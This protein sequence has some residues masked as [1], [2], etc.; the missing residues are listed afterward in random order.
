MS[1]PTIT[2]IFDDFGIAVGPYSSGQISDDR[3]PTLSG[4]LTKKLKKGES[5]FIYSGNDFIGKAETKGKNFSLVSES[6]LKAN[7]T[8]SFKA[9]H[10]NKKGKEGKASKPYILTMTTN[11]LPSLSLMLMG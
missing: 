5:I 11:P 10:V 3:T 8:H 6:K 4:K 1:K 7:Y 2:D 9:V